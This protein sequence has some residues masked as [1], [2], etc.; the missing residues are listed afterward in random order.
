MNM[1]S[2]TGGHLSF[3][4]QIYQSSVAHGPMSIQTVG[5]LFFLGNVF[6]KQ[7]CNPEVALSLHEKV[8]DSYM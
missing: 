2:L 6:F 5:G 8:L 7:S 1:G 3:H 4:L